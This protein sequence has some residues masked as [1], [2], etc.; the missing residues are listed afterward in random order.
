[1]SASRAA[2]RVLTVEDDPIVRADLRLVLEDAG[3]HVCADAR[4][5]VEAVELAEEHRPDVVLLDLGLPR[6]DGAEAT[7]LIRL[8]RDVPVVAL[9]GQPRGELLERAVAAGAVSCVRKPYVVSELVSALVDAVDPP[10]DRAASL[11]FITNLLDVLGHPLEWVVGIE[12]Y[13][14]AAGKVWR[15]VR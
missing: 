13:S 1:M 9:T 4:D 15:E 10:P 5:G 8:D 14:F 6:L 12:E 2:L 3:F 11:R 7:R